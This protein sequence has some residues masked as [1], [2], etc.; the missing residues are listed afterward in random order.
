MKQTVKK[1]LFM[2]GIMC[3]TIFGKE[4]STTVLAD[5]L[6]EIE[7]YTIYAEPDWEDGSVYLKYDITWKVLDSD[8]DGPLEWVKIGIPNSNV[9]EIEGYSSN[10]ENIRYYKNGGSYVRIDFD[11]K[12]YEGETV[13]FSFGIHQHH[14]YQTIDGMRVYRFTPGWFDE[15]VVDE[16]N[17]YWKS[18]N[19]KYVLNGYW[20]QDGYYQF[21]TS[22]AEGEKY[23]VKIEYDADVFQTEDDKKIS[24]PVGTGTKIVMAVML[25]IVPGILLLLIIRAYKKGKPVDSYIAESGFGNAFTDIRTS[26][27]YTGGRGSGGCACA[28]ACAC[29]GGGRAGCSKKDF[30]GTKLTTMAIREALKDTAHEEI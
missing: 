5:N 15:I 11:R 6:D 19:I 23:T 30:Y 4:T 10:I 12:Y 27:H 16:L 29:A 14:L 3:L 26:S 25:L 2:L 20:E 24:H 1:L 22:L 17:I 9:E 21:R 8:T 28:C 7:N 18:D 13:E